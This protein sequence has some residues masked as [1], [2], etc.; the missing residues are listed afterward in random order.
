MWIYI[1]ILFSRER[2]PNISDI[3]FII[4]C[5]SI[6]NEFERDFCRIESLSKSEISK[7]YRS[8]VQFHSGATY[9]IYIYREELLLKINLDR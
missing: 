4:T 6:R 3:M 2:N 7:L 1:Y 5:N 8:L 9:L